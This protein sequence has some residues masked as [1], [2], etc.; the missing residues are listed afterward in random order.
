MFR[1]RNKQNLLEYMVYDTKKEG[2]N[3]Y[4]L[5]YMAKKEWVWI[6]ASPYEPIEK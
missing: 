3:I 1:I 4:F 6:N 5:V 2:P